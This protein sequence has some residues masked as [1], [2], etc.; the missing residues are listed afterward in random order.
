[1][2]DVETYTE[3]GVFVAHGSAEVLLKTFRKADVLE[4]WRGFLEDDLQQRITAVRTR[5][6][7]I[8]R[9]E[10][11]ESALSTSGEVKP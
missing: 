4:Q 7:T 9:G 10:W 3:Y 5:Q 11:Y 2:S 1:M 6:V 8:Q